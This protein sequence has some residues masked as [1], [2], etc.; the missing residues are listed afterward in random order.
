MRKFYQ[1]NAAF[2][3][4]YIC[5]KNENASEVISGAFCIFLER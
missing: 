5:G 4:K 1:N 2:V 3:V